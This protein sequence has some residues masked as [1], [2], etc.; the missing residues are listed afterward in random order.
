MV[1]RMVIVSVFF[2]LLVGGI[3]GGIVGAA[4]NSNG[5]SQWI[6]RT[7]FKQTTT[8]AVGSSTTLSVEEESATTAV[9]KKANPAVVSIIGTKDF[10][11]VYQAPPN[12]FFPFG[13]PFQLRQPQ[14]KQEVSGG[15]GFIVSS[16][17]LIV[18]NKHVVSDEG[19]EYS[20][21]LNDEKRFDA[22]VL[23]KDPT[24]DIAILKIDAR[25]LPILEL[26]DSDAVDIG[27]TVIAI[28]NALGEYRNTVTKGIISGLA[29]TIQAGDSSGMSEVIEDTIQTDTAINPGNSGGPLLNL[30]GQ[31]VGVNTAINTQG[32]LVAFAI[33]VNQVKQDLVSVKDKGKIVRP[34]LGIRY[35]AVTKALKEKNTLPYDYGV[36]VV[37][38]SDPSELAVIPGSPA[39]KA[40][41]VANDLILE[42][43]GERID[44]EHT[45]TGRLSDFNPGDAITL[46]IFHR[47][48]EKTIQVT[49]GERDV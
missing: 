3:V 47:G 1:G 49:L 31:V 16:D 25:D 27:Q 45:L 23:A 35:T 43:N 13:F 14:G 32:Q 26:G 38:G 15:S 41:I 8:V 19:T 36:I 20:V 22:A 29:R 5:L 18:T 2:S 28:G 10:G 34:Y 24:R 30:L 9:V 39:D 37:A 6:D 42:I 7:F 4:T 46:K 33:P 17:G 48:E 11:K 12:D 44:E 40:G 21:V